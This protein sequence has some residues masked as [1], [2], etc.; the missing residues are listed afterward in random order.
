MKDQDE[1]VR[2]RAYQ[3]WEQSGRPDGEHEAHWQ[4]ALEELGLA[5]PARQPEGT[6]VP[7]GWDEEE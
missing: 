3:I 6:T 2:R 5:N 7:P 1:A 4:R